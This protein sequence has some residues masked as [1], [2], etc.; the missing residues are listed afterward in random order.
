MRKLLTKPHRRAV[1]VALLSCLACGGE[2]P[3]PEAE[4]MRAESE[5]DDALDE[6]WLRA[7]QLDAWTGDLDGMVDR[8]FVRFLT[9][10]SRTHY[11]V[12]GARE[13]G[14]VAETAAAFEQ[15]LNKRP[16]AKPVRVVVVPVRRD[17]LLPL[18]RV[19]VGDAA[20]GNLTITPERLQ[21]VDFTPALVSGVRELVV[22]AASVEPPTT[23]RDL[24]GREVWVRAS[25]SYAASLEALNR[26]FAAAGVS[27]IV[28]RAADEHLEDEGVLEMVDAGIYPATV[29]DSHKLSWVWAKVFDNILVSDV[30]IREK[31]EIGVAIRKDSPLLRKELAEFYRL[32]GV[33][34]T[35]GN[36]VVRRYF[37]VSRWTGPPSSSREQRRFAA[38]E[39]LF[40]A[41][42]QRYGFDPLMMVAQGY[43]ESQL[44][45]T[46]RSGA[47]AV[48]IM[49]LLPA[50][51]ASAPVGIAD[52]ASPENNIHAGIKYMRH[53]VDKYFADPEI[54]EINRYLFALAA[55]NAGPT[56]IAR[57]RR[58]A[59]E[60]GLDPNRWFRNVEHVVATKVGRE[61]V[62]YVAN[63]YKHYLAFRRLREI[64]SQRGF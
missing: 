47:G 48:G 14:I 26:E 45:P 36:I 11:F 53:L 8:G 63:V 29:V 9:P 28:V 5:R 55:Y 24:A 59:P 17:Q 35:F 60:Y 30:A 33:G 39:G 21:S 12:D 46:A 10:A 3:S 1:L 64:E 37:D 62:R 43:Q 25:S 58:S 40:R 20:L 6:P 32:H 18:L 23:V 44:D 7:A 56:R 49:Q 57:L 4:P 54:D 34:T 42:S 31:G 13:R 22:T 51:A 19:G 41:Y 61:P 38:V 52:V 16:G 27:P 15:M 2:T 50:T